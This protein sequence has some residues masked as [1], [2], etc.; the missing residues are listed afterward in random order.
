MPEYNAYQQVFGLSLISNSL[1]KHKGTQADLQAACEAKLPALLKKELQDQWE[2]TWGPVVWKHDPHDFTK[3]PDHIWFVARNPSLKF[4]DGEHRDTYVASI[5]GSATIYNW[6]DNFRVNQVVD[7]P[8]W[9]KN[10]LVSPPLPATSP[11]RNGCYIALGTAR[12]VYRLAT[13]TPPQSAAG[14]GVPL[15]TY[16]SSF[17]PSAHTKVIFTGHSLG[18]ALSPTLALGLLN[19]LAFIKFSP[20][21]ILL[22]PTAGP[23]TGNWQFVQQLQT[24]FPKTPGPRYEVWNC[25]IVNNLDIVSQAWCTS[26]VASPEQNMD[27]IPSI[28]GHPLLWSVKTAVKESKAR[29]N[30]SRVIY[31]PFQPLRFEGTPPSSPHNTISEFLDRAW[32]QHT[33]EFGKRFGI[34]IPPVHMEEEEG[35]VKMTRAEVISTEPIFN[36][37]VSKA[38]QEADGA[39]I[40]EGDDDEEKVV[41]QNPDEILRGDYDMR[42]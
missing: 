28:Y 26:A 4:A 14:S 12:G 15:P 19:S 25:N 6:F 38:S 35:V 24:A 1:R 33:D 2:I 31:M 39:D 10:G 32:E 29:A 5:A 34:V 18:A 23:N 8:N 40:E 13:V 22:Y 42:D 36:D 11:S 27:N 41:D 20:E 9:L 7:F 21:N 16:W 3:G 30:A 37:I 17:P